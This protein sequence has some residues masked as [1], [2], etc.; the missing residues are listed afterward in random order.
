MTKSTV[1]NRPI[2]F[3]NAMP[4]FAEAHPIML[5]RDYKRDWIE[6]NAK[7]LHAFQEELKKCPIDY[8]KEM[9][10]KYSG[11]IVR[12]PGIRA[13]MNS[14]YIIPSPCDI[15]IETN[16]DGNTFKA[17]DL[18]P[19]G[20]PR[21][22]F[23]ISTAHP[24]EQFHDF[25]AV[26]DNTVKSVIKVITGWNVVPDERFVFLVTPP[27]YCNEHRFSGPVGIQDPFSDTQIN[28][29]LYWHILK[30]RETIKAGTPLA[31]YIP[32][33]R[34]FVQPDIVCETA[35]GDI[36][37]KFIA[38]QNLIRLTTDRSQVKIK[39]AVKRVFKKEIGNS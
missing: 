36:I 39:E 38:L 20:G 34:E 14:G 13:F 21:G 15:I 1:E 8:Y 18:A 37:D 22:A 28:I 2:R 5:A 32:I 30:G 4:G 19:Q 26:P 16:G 12:C 29:F 25:T 24:R 9:W 17:A 23:K 27:H 3:C 31:Q 35:M 6:K 33:P 10:Q 7:H 11:H